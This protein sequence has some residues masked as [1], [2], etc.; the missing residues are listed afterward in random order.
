M[1]GEPKMEEPVL[2]QKA[3]VMWVVRANEEITAG[4]KSQVSGIITP[5]DPKIVT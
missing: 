3:H 5:K 4:Y 2:F 1:F